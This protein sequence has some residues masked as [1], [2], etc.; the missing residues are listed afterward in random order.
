LEDERFVK[1]IGATLGRDLIAKKSGR[2]R[3][4]AAK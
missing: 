4:A 2:K 3:K 1:H